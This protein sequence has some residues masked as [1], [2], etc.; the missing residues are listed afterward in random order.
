MNAFETVLFLYSFGFMAVMT[1]ATM[2][3]MSAK[4]KGKFS[5]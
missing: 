4:S 1:V 2:F 5:Y 3:M